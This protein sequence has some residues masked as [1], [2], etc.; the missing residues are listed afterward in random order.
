[1]VLHDAWLVEWED[2]KEPWMQ[3]V[4]YKLQADFQLGIP[5]LHMIQ[6][7]PVQEECLVQ[8]LTYRKH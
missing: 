8:R 6:G 4:D 5:S 2:N 3:R 1:M 7:S